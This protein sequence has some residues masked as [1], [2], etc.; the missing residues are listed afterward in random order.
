MN[1]F[2][3]EEELQQLGLKAYGENVLISRKCSIYGAENISIGNHVRIDDFCI[4]SGNITLHN[5]IHISAYAALYAGSSTIEIGDYVA[6][7]SRNAVYAESDDYS[8]ESMV[9]P[10][11]P[12]ECRKVESAPVVI[13][14]HV[15]IGTGG[16]VLPGVT[17]GEG[18]SIGAM[19]LINHDINP[20]SINVGIPCRQIKERSKKLLTYEKNIPTA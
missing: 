14:R 20:W 18:A 6:V 13:C 7:S 12:E 10:M 3:S 2:Y 9:N 8:G 19:S 16:T 5:Y 1:S 4:L 17:I 15:I 11:V